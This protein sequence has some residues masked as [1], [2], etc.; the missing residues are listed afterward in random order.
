MH[1]LLSIP[2]IMSVAKALQLIKAGS[3]KFMNEHVRHRFEW[4]EGYGAFTVGVAQKEITAAYIRNQTEHHRKRGFAQEYASF[5]AKNGFQ[6]G[7]D[8]AIVPAGL[9][10]SDQ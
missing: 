7:D 9:V 10:D 4:Q 8:G 5:L 2:P 6:V 3:S 1:V